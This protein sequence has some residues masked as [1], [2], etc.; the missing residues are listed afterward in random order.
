MLPRAGLTDLET[1]G[2][3]RERHLSLLNL[4]LCKSFYLPH[5]DL[6]LSWNWRF[7]DSSIG[8]HTV[9]L[10]WKLRLPPGHHWAPDYEGK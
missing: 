2:W 5:C 7:V 9:S 8:E 10:D 1:K 3:K 6:E 4:V